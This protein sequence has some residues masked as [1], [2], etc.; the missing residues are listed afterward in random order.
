[1]AISVAQIWRFPVKS[2]RGE[3]IDEG[4]LVESGLQGD[5]RFGVVDDETGKVLSAKREARLLLASARLV[6]DGVEIDLPDGTTVS[7]ADSDVDARLSAWLDRSVSLRRAS[8]DVQTVYEM[9]TDNTDESSPL[10]DFPCPPGTFLDAAAVHLLTTASL[11]A[12]AAEYPEGDWDVRRFR[13]TVLL[14][15]D[16]DDWVEDGW[17][18]GPVT[19]GEAGLM[20]FAPT[21]RCAV[22]T[23]AQDGLPRDLGIAKT[24]NR[25]HQSNLG[26]YAAVAS[27]GTVRIGDRVTLS[28]A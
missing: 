2:M 8:A 7:S 18:G 23:R 12:A 16:G 20:V 21:V 6:G 24:V 17:V 15:C 28:S 10:F 3:R 13:P 4:P 19:V 9:N 25:A 5:R 1:M 22:P 27:P 11:R 26:V 14:E